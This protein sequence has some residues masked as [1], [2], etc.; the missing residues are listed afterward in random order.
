M[1]RGVNS[2]PVMAAIF[3][4]ITFSGSS[5]RTV[6][7]QMESLASLR[8]ELGEDYIAGS[9]AR[10]PP[11]RIRQDE[12]VLVEEVQGGPCVHL[13]PPDPWRFLICS[14]K[15]TSR[16]SRRRLGAGLCRLLLS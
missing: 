5:K 16:R 15:L 14:D 10:A 8:I 9:Q 3:L 4:G 2:P 1:M 12:I 6:A 7:Q 13:M 11:L